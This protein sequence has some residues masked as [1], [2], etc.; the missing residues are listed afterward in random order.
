MRLA[1]THETLGERSWLARGPGRRMLQKSRWGRGR[2]SD[3][4]GWAET[5]WMQV[6][7]KKTVFKNKQET[8][9]PTCPKG[10]KL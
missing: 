1:A 10:P 5:G 8:N 7:R 9:K 2:G 3:A 4:V 6:I